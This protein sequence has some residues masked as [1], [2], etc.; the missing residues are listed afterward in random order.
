MT[1]VRFSALTPLLQRH[2]RVADTWSQSA[3]SKRFCLFLENP[4][5]APQHHLVP[6]LPGFYLF[7]LKVVIFPEHAVWDG[8]EGTEPLH[9][10]DF[11]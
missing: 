11:S 1:I 9:L 10:L 3:R 6:K 8:D 2:W 7:S 5:P 4:S